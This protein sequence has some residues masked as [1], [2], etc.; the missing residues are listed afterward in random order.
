MVMSMEFLPASREES[1]ILG[2]LQPDFVLVT[3]DAYVDH[4]SFG[5]AIIG[6]LLE[7]HGY[8]VA[9]LSQPDWKNPD[10]FRKFGRPR[11][12]F[13]ITS[14]C[15]DSMVNNYSV[16]KRRR[17]RDVYS[18]EGV[19]GRRPD[20]AI[21]V[22]SNVARQAYRDCPI[23]IG[24]LEASLRRLGHYDYWDNKLRRSILLDSKADILI[25]GMGE[26]GIL[27]VAEALNDGF[28]SRDIT[29]V[30]GTVFRQKTAPDE[31]VILPDFHL[32]EDRSEYVRSFKLQ[33]D[34]S[35]SVNAQTLAEG[36]GDGLFVVQNPPQAPLGRAELDELYDLPF[37]R[38][39]HPLFD[40]GTG[41]PALTEV[42]FSIC[43]SRGCFGNCSF[44]ALTYHQGRLVTSRSKKSIVSEGEKLSKMA[45]FKGYIHDVGG[46]TANFRGPA[47]DRQETKGTCLRRDCLF[48]SPCE[49][50]A[51]DQSEFLAVLRGLRS[52]PGV[53]KVF[54]RSGLRYDYIMAD[55]AHEEIIREICEF[56][57]SGILKVAPE[58]VVPEVLKRMRKPGVEVYELFAKEFRKAN[59][60]LGKEQYLLPY[61]ISSHPG[62]GLNEAVDLALY[63]RRSGFVPEQSQDFY[64]SPGTAGACMYYTG[65]D[66]FT[67]EQV[68]SPRTEEDKRL[69]W[70]LLHF[71][72]RENRRTVE[73]ALS[74]AGRREV[75]W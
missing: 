2:W 52:I 68:Y 15:V 53:K 33:Y 22:Y 32:L 57:V 10:D 64:P 4:P 6:R 38:E 28:S 39:T 60:S 9:V 42:K 54:I 73:K 44:C 36:Y 45:D 61:F 50:L 65:I 75:L 71:N 40:R 29:W 58:H 49:R 55:P 12:G 34:N 47:C 41:V 3:G 37:M 69:Q 5:S 8:K 19:A 18:P 16:M 46:P 51:A 26:R 7:K 13:L 1:E 70:A 67:G 48:P 14:G 21:I 31:S 56:H 35:E 66:P 25:Y 20:R 59:E 43:A 63:L 30:R 23:I 62:S 11:L 72:K 74:M 24:G 17:K 27:E